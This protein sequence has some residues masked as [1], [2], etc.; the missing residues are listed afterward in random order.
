MQGSG[1]GLE[2]DGVAEA[3]ELGD[4]PFGLAFRGRGGR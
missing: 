1:G 3:F 4:Q 2:R